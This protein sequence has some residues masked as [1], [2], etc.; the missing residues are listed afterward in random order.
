MDIYSNDDSLKATIREDTLEWEV[1]IDGST[2]EEGT[3]DSLNS[4]V[5][6]SCSAIESVGESVT[7]AW[8]P[9]GV[10]ADILREIERIVSAVEVCPT[11][12]ANT[13][14][15]FG[16]F[17]C[18]ETIDIPGATVPVVLHIDADDK[19]WL[20]IRRAAESLGLDPNAQLRSLKKA[21]WCE[22]AQ[23]AVPNASGVVRMSPFIALESVPMWLAQIDTSKVKEPVR[24]NIIAYQREASAVLYEY[25][26][27]R[28]FTA[29]ATTTLDAETA[30]A[31]MSYMDDL[32]LHVNSQLDALRDDVSERLNGLRDRLTA[33]VPAL[34]TA[35]PAPA[36]VAAPVVIDAEVNEDDSFVEA[37]AAGPVQEVTGS[38]IPALERT[39]WQTPNGVRV[40]TARQWLHEIGREGG[41]RVTLSLGQH[42]AWVGEDFGV[43]P[44]VKGSRN[45][46]SAQVWKEAVSRY[47]K[48]QAEL[49]TKEV[50]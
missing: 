2:V 22:T 47:D 13:P 48:R 41:M 49:L 37:V 3:S 38:G 27:T 30:A 4:A 26:V 14:S 15:A 11:T 40:Y 45:L 20:N 39:P 7:A 24:S 36:L 33:A 43:L 31:L 1:T 8:S 12:S 10:P 50:S 28:R 35:K 5:K 25:M 32:Q 34:N 44:V 29:P 21:E 23:W 46:W 42:A 16:A 6:L 9:N 17:S 19:G 18:V